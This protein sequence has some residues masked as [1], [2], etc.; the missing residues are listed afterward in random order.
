MAL[1]EQQEKLCDDSRWD[2]SDL[3]AIFLNCTSSARR[4]SPTP[5]G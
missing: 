4:S 1:N 2:F 3:N 5:R